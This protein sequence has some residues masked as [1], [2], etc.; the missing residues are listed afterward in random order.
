MP[1]VGDVNQR[2]H[3]FLDG[4]YHFGRTMSEQVTAPTWEEVEV[5]FSFTVPDIGSF[6]ADETHRIAAVIWN[7][8]LFKQINCFVGAECGIGTHRVVLLVKL[9]MVRIPEGLGRKRKTAKRLARFADA[10]M[11]CFGGRSG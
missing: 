6:T 2:C 11:P 8:V 10:R 3:L 1:T 5:T 4:G 9:R 7:D